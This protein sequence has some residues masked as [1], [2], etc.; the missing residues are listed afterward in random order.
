MRQNVEVWSLERRVELIQGTLHILYRGG[1]PGTGIALETQFIN[2]QANTEPAATSSLA[3]L[4]S[5][6]VATDPVL[7]SRDCLDAPSGDDDDMIRLLVLA[8]L[9]MGIRT[10]DDATFVLVEFRCFR[11]DGAGDRTT[12]EDLSLHLVN[13]GHGAVFINTIKEDLGCGEEMAGAVPGANVALMIAH[14]VGRRH[15]SHFETMAPIQSFEW[16]AGIVCKT[17]FMDEFV[18]QEVATAIAGASGGTFVEVQELLRSQLH[19]KL[20]ASGDGVTI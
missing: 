6:A 4:R 3:P 17:V 5:V 16:R 14:F 15:R 10:G 18:G 20:V 13:A 19:A 12:R 11:V 8:F 7:L 9:V 1:G 2:T